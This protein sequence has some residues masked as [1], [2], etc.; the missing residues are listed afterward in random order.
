[1]PKDQRSETTPRRGWKVPEW[2]RMYDFGPS[3]SYQLVR[4]GK[5][6]RAALVGGELIITDEADEEWRRALAE[7]AA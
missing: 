5:G 2:G 4:T 7:Q 6:P 1:M 3:K